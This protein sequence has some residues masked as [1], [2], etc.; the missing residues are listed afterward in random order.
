MAEG[1]AF[2]N[3]FFAVRD[4]VGKRHHVA[5][6]GACGGEGTRA[7]AIEHGLTHGVANDKHGVHGARYAR[8]LVCRGNHGGVHAHV[9]AAF[10]VAGNGEQLNGV[11][12]L[13]RHFDIGGGNVANSLHEHVVGIHARAEADGGENRDFRSGIEAVDVGRGVGFGVTQALCIGKH[14]I[15][16][17]AL[18][19]HA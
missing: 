2:G 7:R 12:E 1:F 14:F 19:G 3:D 4:M 16:A 11:A 13:A 9:D 10:G 8:E 5:H 15:E 17:Q 6:H 18:V